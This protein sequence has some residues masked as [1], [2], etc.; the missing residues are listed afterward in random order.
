[1]VV[2]ETVMAGAEF[3]YWLHALSPLHPG[4]GRGDGYIDLPLA[5]EKATLFP[6]VPGSTVKGVYA[7]ACGAT[8]DARNPKKPGYDP[9]LHA[10]FGRT[11][12]D[13][14]NAGALVFTDARLICLPIRSLFG[15]FAWC[16]SRLVL[17]RLARDFEMANQN[18]PAVPAETTDLDTALVPLVGESAIVG[19]E[20]KAFLEDLD[21]ACLSCEKVAAWAERIAKCVFPVDTDPWRGEF[22]KRFVVLPDLV[23]NFLTETGTEVRPHVRIDPELKRAVDGALWYEESLPAETILA[24]LVWLDPVRGGAKVRELCVSKVGPDAIQI[25]G[26]A[27]VGKGRTRLLFAER[28]DATTPVPEVHP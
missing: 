14:G 28:I 24:G 27:S 23:F 20:G 22:S 17:R 12:E 10:A 16:T 8:D 11:G 4:A 5:R 25:G 1:M 26:K 9:V 19:R 18:A 7:D 15:T 6:F 3:V 21:L 2:K 13:T